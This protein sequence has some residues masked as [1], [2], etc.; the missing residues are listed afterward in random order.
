MS[1]YAENFCSTCVC[2]TAAVSNGFVPHWYR[3]RQR[4]AARLRG[5]TPVQAAEEPRDGQDEV[6]ARTGRQE[7]GVI[8]M[9][10]GFTATLRS[11]ESM[12]QQGAVHAP[13]IRHHS[14]QIPTPWPCGKR[15]SIGCLNT[16]ICC[17]S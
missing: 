3:A 5:C 1:M 17:T 6:A 10:I 11:D 9:A 4:P 15:L 13:N 14:A 7:F 8:L 2:V 16:A 12:H